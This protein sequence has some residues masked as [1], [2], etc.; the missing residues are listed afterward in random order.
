MHVI[1]TFLFVPCAR[2]PP[3]WQVRRIGEAS[4]PGPGKFRLRR[5][6]SLGNPGKR[7]ERLRVWQQ[8]QWLRGNPGQLSNED[9]DF[10]RSSV[11]V[12]HLSIQG[13][14]AHATE[15]AA[16]LRLEET[17]RCS[18]VLMKASSSLSCILS[19]KATAL[20]LVGT[21]QTAKGVAGLLCMFLM[22][23]VNQSLMLVTLSKTSDAG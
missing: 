15:L 5:R 21:G 19:S 8:W 14:E 16:R 20:Q 6:G 13:L 12:W 3:F 23:T 2:R 18:Y 1:G 9:A 11:K 17:N 4:N 7:A 22:N 10:F